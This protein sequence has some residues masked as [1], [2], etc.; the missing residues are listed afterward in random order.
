[1]LDDEG[2]GPGPVEPDILVVESG[3]FASRMSGGAAVA[4]LDPVLVRQ[5]PAERVERW[6]E[7][8][9]VT[10]GN[11]VVTVIEVLSPGDKASGDLNRKYREKL[12][13]YSDGGANVVEIDLLRSSPER[14]AVPM[15]DLPRERCAAYCACVKRVADPDL[16]AA[17]PIPLRNPL[18]TLPVPCREGEDDV[19]LALQ[20]IID[21]IYEEGAYDSIDYTVPPRPPLSAADAAWA[22]ELI[23]PRS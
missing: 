1:M 9:D 16:W 20:P 5:L 11:R 23:K 13:R 10:D 18:P 8:I 2:D 12:R 17:Y 7:V 22:A 14:L 6:V 15:H 19:A 21:R 3:P 4:T